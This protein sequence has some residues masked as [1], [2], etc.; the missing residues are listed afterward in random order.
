MTRA[1]AMISGG[2]DSI[3]AAKLIKEQGIDVI[4]NTLKK[5]AVLSENCSFLTIL[6]NLN[7]LEPKCL[8][9]YRWKLKLS[10]KLVLTYYS[11]CKLLRAISSHASSI[12]SVS[13]TLPQV[14]T[15]IC[16]LIKKNDIVASSNYV[17]GPL[18]VNQIL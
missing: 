16:I 9:Q 14:L 4:V 2:L 3:L 18:T 13:L 7:F 17:V 6:S 10:F 8:K 12:S 15:V 1:L 11:G 5:M